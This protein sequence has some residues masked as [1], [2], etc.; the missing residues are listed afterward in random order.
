ME[1]ELIELL[2]KHPQIKNLIE[3]LDTVERLPL[4]DAERRAIPPF[5]IAQF[6]EET[7][8]GIIKNYEAVIEE[9]YKNVTDQF[10]WLIASYYKNENA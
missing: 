8:K 5:S 6:K 7:Q 10:R 1:D 9:A 3:R 2:R 4:D